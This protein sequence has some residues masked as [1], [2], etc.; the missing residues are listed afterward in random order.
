MNIYQIIIVSAL[1]GGA[2]VDFIADMLNLRRLSPQLPDEF[3][4]VHDSASYA[5]SQEYTRVNTRFGW[6]SSAFSLLI[7]FVFWG[8]GGFAALHYWLD[9]MG[10]HMVPTGLLY[11]GVLVMAR[12]FLSLPFKIYSTF[13]IEGRFGF[14]LTTPKTFVLDILKSL[15]VGLIIGVPLLATVLFLFDRAGE[16]AWIYAWAVATVIMLFVQFI[17]PRWIMPLFNEFKPLE[18]KELKEKIEKMAKAARFP[19][20]EISVMDGS[21]RS[22]KSNAFFAGFGRNRRIALF[23]TLIDNHTKDEVVA[24]LAHEIGHFRK[25]HIPLNIIL[26]IVHSGILFYLLSV[27][28]QHQGL[29]E[30][31]HITDAQPVYAGMIFFSLLYKPIEMILSV[32]LGM[33]SRRCEYAADNFAAEL[34]NKGETLA[35]ALKK[36]SRNNLS[37]LTP[38]PFYVFLNYSHPPILERIR[39]L[40][41]LHCQY[42]KT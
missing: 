12:T 14:N 39:F 40:K 41:K 26:G 20:Q 35:E 13:V 25:K 16:W 19:F 37:N 11:I 3:K 38:H 29:F 33:L 27:F 4:D 23:D 32:L 42:E 28:L 6:I 5:R 31:F 15:L 8:M 1:L 7:L 24:V 9:G 30:A 17:A 18:D 10:W 34:T 21:R 2:F 36:L 22:S